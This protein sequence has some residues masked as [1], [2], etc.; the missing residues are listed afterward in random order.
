MG[1]LID[2]GIV[3]HQAGRLK[4]AS[5]AYRKALEADPRNADAIHL[6][7]VILHQEGNHASGLV[8]IDRAINIRPGEA[9]FHSNRADCLRSLGR[10]TEAEQAAREAIR[11]DPT[12]GEAYNLVG[13]TL[14]DRGDLSGGEAMVREAIRL[15]P[16]NA[17]AHNNLAAL[18]RQTGGVQTA[19]DEYKAAVDAAPMQ[20]QA[21]ANY[22]QALLESDRVDEA[23]GFCMKALALAPAMPEGFN[24]LGN[25]FRA[26][27]QDDVALALYNRALALRPGQAM[28]HCNIG[29]LLM[30]VG[31]FDEAEPAF[32]RA[33]ELEP[34][35]PRFHC[36][37]GTWCEENGRLDDALR[38][39]QQAVAVAPN[40][41]EPHVGV[42]ATLMDLDR[43]DDAKPYL[44]RALT[45][46]GDRVHACLSMARWC[47]EKGDMT[48]GEAMA[49]EALRLK[50]GVPG[51]LHYLA[52]ALRDKLPE[53]ELADLRTQAASTSAPD[54]A[55]CSTNFSLAA[56]LDARKDYE[57]AAA[58]M[59]EANACQIRVRT[60]RGEHYDRTRHTAF[61]GRAI[62]AFPAERLRAMADW[63]NPTNVPIFILGMPRSGTTLVEQIISSHPD[64]YGAGEL[65][66][67][68]KLWESL[69]E[70]FKNSSNFASECV[71]L[72]THDVVQTMA[73]EML[74]KLQAF[75]P[76]SPRITDK[77]PD[78]YLYIGLIK[79]LYPNA[80]IIH[81]Q[82]N[83]RDIGLSCYITQFKQIRWA[84]DVQDIGQRFVD[85]QRIMGHW[86]T[87]LPAGSWLDVEYENNVADL[88][89][90]A[91]RMLD[92]LGLSWD[93]RCLDFHL[94]DR[95]VKTASVAQVRQPLYN[96][97]VER[98]RRYE[99]YLPE[100][101]N[102]IPERAVAGAQKG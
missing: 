7:G 1:T 88:E 34:S 73:S 67:M 18:L 80:K 93:P 40:A 46:T 8:D 71:P 26:R 52:A 64:V 2:D 51:G 15:N 89:G 3:H 58:A 77:M 90:S 37:Y 39:F 81:C 59:R 78:N 30:A 45:C 13:A 70:R 6:L 23:L 91:R 69:P 92:Y 25:I 47:T 66:L 42:G 96:R 35:N 24:N 63:G 53:A 29:Q 28:T 4:Q 16:R 17:S 85:Y 9:T 49:R 36:M 60:K 41:S 82:R 65:S 100:L 50:P 76:T 74:G 101:F 22:G 83:L 27:G 14:I 97:S 72:F 48:R 21:L 98:W 102:A 68:A 11:L 33:I 32:K 10:P 95:A 31:K 75:A 61:V 94:N 54:G 38:N 12:L 19:L 56:V 5:A 99:A 57:P 44:E 84:N 86:R 79:T 43:Y 20:V 87:V 55:R 62:D